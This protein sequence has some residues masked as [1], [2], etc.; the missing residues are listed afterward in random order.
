MD[1]YLCLRVHDEELLR[2][3]SASSSERWFL[4][5]IAGTRC[6][7]SR[8][9]PAMRFVPCTRDISQMACCACE[10]DKF[11]NTGRVGM[12]TQLHPKL[13]GFLTGHHSSAHVPRYVGQ[14]RA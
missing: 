9:C 5:D 3:Y 6:V 14:G 13:V 10:H 8:D 2:F 7:A 1:T 12:L 11:P 4:N